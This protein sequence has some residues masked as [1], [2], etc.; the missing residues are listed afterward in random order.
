M[1]Q[2]SARAITSS[3]IAET[4]SETTCT[5]SYDKKASIKFQISPMKDVRGVA[6]T[7]SDGGKD[8]QND[9]RTDGER[10]HTRTD[11]GHL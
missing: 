8:G 9:G 3:K 11:E 5:S 2:E 6:G 7:R 1:W 4:K 10:T